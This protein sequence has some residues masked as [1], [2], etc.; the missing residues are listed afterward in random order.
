MNKYIQKLE[1]ELKVVMISIDLSAFVSL[2]V[3][4]SF[5]SV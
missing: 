5:L 4:P 2:S 3:S 1:G